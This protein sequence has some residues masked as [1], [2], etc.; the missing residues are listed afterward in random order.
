MAI[1]AVLLLIL[2]GTLLAGLIAFGVLSLKPSTDGDGVLNALLLGPVGVVVIGND[3]VELRS[4]DS[5]LTVVVPAGSVTSPITLVYRESGLSE[6]PGLPLGFISTGRF[7]ELSAQSID[8]AAGPVKFQQMISMTMVIGPNELALAGNDYSRFFIQHYL[9]ETMSWDVLPTTADLRASTVMAQ[10]GSLSRFALTVGPSRGI[11]SSLSQKREQSL[12][13]LHPQPQPP[14]SS[15]YQR[16]SPRLP[17]R[18]SPAPTAP[19]TPTRVPTPL[20]TPTPAP[21]ATLVPA[22]SPTPTAIPAPTP[23]PAPAATPVPTPTPA[24]TPIPPPTATPFPTPT[25]TPLPY[26][27]GG[28]MAFQ[29]SRSGNLEVMIMGLDGNNPVALT[30]DPASDTEPSWCGSETLV[31]VSDG[32]SI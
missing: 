7:F 18:S 9:N 1:F 24:P 32:R 4:V 17:Q 11:V 13:T 15:L 21:T 10:V 27:S 26:V 31:F 16:K 25:P 20:P 6:A 29:S 23:T 14:P 19:P 2:L 5:L 30:N 28:R 3:D 12:L 22:P 8:T